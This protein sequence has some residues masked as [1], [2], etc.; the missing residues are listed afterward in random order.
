[1]EEE[2]QIK[3]SM[4]SAA[5]E[6]Y[7]VV[8]HTKW[9][10]LASASFCRTDRLTGVFTDGDAPPAMVAAL[11]EMGIQVIEIDRK[12]RTGPAGRGR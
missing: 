3:R 9:G 11:R 6:V 12:A 4:V 10:R 1:M 5:R 2:A 8:D 7:A